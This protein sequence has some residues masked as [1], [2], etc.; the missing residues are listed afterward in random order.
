[1]HVAK[2]LLTSHDVPR[3]P[4][5]QKQLKDFDEVL[6]QQLPPFGSLHCSEEMGSRGSQVLI[7]VHGTKKGGVQG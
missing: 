5:L 7:C 1:M 3:N 6:K 2:V 4:M